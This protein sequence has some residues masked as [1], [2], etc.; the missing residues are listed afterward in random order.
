MHAVLK[1]EDVVKCSADPF[2]QFVF[3]STR[4]ILNHITKRFCID[5]V[6][7]VAANLTCF[8]PTA[9]QNHAQNLELLLTRRVR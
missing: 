3:S 9:I 4:Q 6:D 1:T 2:N 8:K 7:A 5:H